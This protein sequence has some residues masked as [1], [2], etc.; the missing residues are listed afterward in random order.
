MEKLSKQLIIDEA[1]RVFSPGSQ[2]WD[3]GALSKWW[4]W[5]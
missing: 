3:G 5:D 4:R 2:Q 1:R